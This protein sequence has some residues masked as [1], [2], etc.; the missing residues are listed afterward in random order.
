MI[1]RS[2]EAHIRDGKREEF[3]ATLVDL[4]ATFA[5]RYP[6]LVGHSILIDSTDPDRVVYQSTW[7]DQDAVRDFAGDAW[8]TEPVTFAGE[9]ELLREPLRLRHF[10]TRDVDKQEELEDFAPLD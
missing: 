4:V 8:A 2:S 3:M 10:E 1:V 7:A 9:D 5:G 6:G